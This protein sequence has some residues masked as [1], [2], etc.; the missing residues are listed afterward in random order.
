MKSFHRV[1]FS[2]FAVLIS[3]PL[4]SVDTSAMVIDVRPIAIYAAQA[5]DA[6]LVPMTRVGNR[7]LGPA[8]SYRR[9]SIEGPR[10]RGGRAITGSTGRW[11]G[12]RKWFSSRGRFTRNRG[13]FTG[14]TWFNKP[15]RQGVSNYRKQGSISRRNLE[16]LSHRNRSVA[17]RTADLSAL[18]RD[19]GRVLGSRSGAGVTLSDRALRRLIRK[20][21]P[22]A[23]PIKPRIRHFKKQAK[24]KSHAK[25]SYKRYG[26]SR[27]NE[28]YDSR[29]RRRGSL[30]S[31]SP[32][33]RHY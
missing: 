20:S 28:I 7:M 2:V 17:N 15:R 8:R 9:G 22:V 30:G 23:L 1:I 27:R 12:G 18:P 19:P 6:V 10:R 21:Y 3:A 14:R 26:V 25:R 11:F 32:Y 5:S 24:I 31:M 16:G 33:V 4:A 29:I 13:W